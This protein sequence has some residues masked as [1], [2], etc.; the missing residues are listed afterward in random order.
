MFFI[1]SPKIVLCLFF[2]PN[3]EQNLHWHPL[4]QMF[5]LSRQLQDLGSAKSSLCI[6]S[7]AEFIRIKAI[8]PTHD[9]SSSIYFC[10]YICIYKYMKYSYILYIYTHTNIIYYSYITYTQTQELSINTQTKINK[11][12]YSYMR[13]AAASANSSLHEQTPNHSIKGLSTVPG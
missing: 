8:M 1:C 10:L 12:Q 13:G 4:Y 2:L 11:S 7:W 9:Y 5:H 6:Y 3:T